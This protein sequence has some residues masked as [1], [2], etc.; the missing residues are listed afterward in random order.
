MKTRM[1]P[2][3]AVAV[4]IVD[5]VLLAT[6]AIGPIAALALLIALELPLGAISVASYLRRYR[7]HR[8][9]S[10]TRRN[11]LKALVAEDPFLRMGAVEA[12]TFASL[13]RWIARRPDVPAGAT[14]IGYSR[15][16]L[17]IP[18]ALSIAAGIEV[19][20]VHLLIPWPIVRLILD[21]GGL[22][23]LL[24]FLGL[25]A[26]WI[27]RPHLLTTDALV[28]RSGPHVCTRVPL[29]ALARVLRD[30]QMGSTA[31][32]IVG[33]DNATLVLAGPDGT[34]VTLGLTR[35]VL[36]SVPGY[37]WS[38]PE[39]SEVS[40][41]RMHVDEPDV[42]VALLRNAVVVYGADIPAE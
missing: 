10:K 40:S 4:V 28:L 33:D 42:I 29:D 9:A 26:G 13:G 16:T 27:V 21:L 41:I 25:L 8:A 17:G 35:S 22:Y 12:R 38:A 20:A 11:A 15:G 24:M 1:L 2:A 6:G 3:I 39:R 18:I 37:P 31:A 32:E 19:I 5:A 23:A 30:R 36:A 14:P 34:S 7:G